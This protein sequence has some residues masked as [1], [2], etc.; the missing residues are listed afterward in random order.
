LTTGRVL[1]GIGGHGAGGR[2]ARA[3]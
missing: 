1:P 2:G 3:L